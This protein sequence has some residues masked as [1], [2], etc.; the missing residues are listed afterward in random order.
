M[1]QEDGRIDAYLA[2]FIEK[3]ELDGVVISLGNTGN[4]RRY[5]SLFFTLKP[6]SGSLAVDVFRHTTDACRR[7]RGRGEERLPC[8]MLVVT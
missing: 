8:P 5:P 6:D 3:D 4:L 1:G 2:S 7:G